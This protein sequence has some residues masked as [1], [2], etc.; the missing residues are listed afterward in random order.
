M[1]LDPALLVRRTSVSAAARRSRRWRYRDDG[2]IVIAVSTILRPLVRPAPARHRGAGPVV[3]QRGA[4]TRSP[5]PVFRRPRACGDAREAG[6]CRRQDHREPEPAGHGNVGVDALAPRRF[7]SITTFRGNSG[8]WRARVVTGPG[9]AGRWSVPDRH[10]ARRLEGNSWARSSASRQSGSPDPTFS[11]DGF[12]ALPEPP[13]RRA[14]ACSRTGGWCLPTV[15]ASGGLTA[16][17]APDLAFGARRRR[18]APPAA[19]RGGRRRSRSAAVDGRGRHEPGL[20]FTAA[21]VDRARCRQRVQTTGAA[22]CS[23]AQRPSRRVVFESGD[24]LIVAG[25]VAPKRSRWRLGSLD[26]TPD[27]ECVP[28]SEAVAACAAAVG[29]A[30]CDDRPWSP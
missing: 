19:P 3:R 10:R 4:F 24:G 16:S 2:R 14:R 30:R 6:C 20:G 26:G 17:G 1:R 29:T 21:S 11:G 25:S 22:R 8:V 18:Q 15:R 5:G 23:R 9:A 12:A 27:V 7:G 28:M 13:R